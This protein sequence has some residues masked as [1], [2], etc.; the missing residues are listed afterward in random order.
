MRSAAAARRT[1]A[2]SVPAATASLRGDHYMTIDGKKPQRPWE[3]ISGF[4]KVKDGRTHSPSLQFPRIC[5]TGRPPCWALPP[6]AMPWRAPV[7]NGTARRWKRRSTTVADAPAS[8][9]RPRSGRLI[10]ISRRENDAADGDHADR[11]CAAGA[12]GAGTKTACG[13]PRAGSDPRHRRS[14]LRAHACR[15]WRRGAKVSRPDLADSGM[16][17]L[18]ARHRKA[19]DLSRFPRCRA[20][21]AIEGSHPQR[22]R[23][24]PVLSARR[25]CVSRLRRG[26]PRRHASR[27][28]RRNAERLGA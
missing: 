19:V 24:R 21:G 14:A 13:H 10:R 8:S 17:D 4:Y 9:A 23:V 27:H 6:S 15:A 28:R 26:G 1:I 5:A 18:V 7:C 2:I 25:A 12:A 11:R 16:L 3:D 20:E 22:R